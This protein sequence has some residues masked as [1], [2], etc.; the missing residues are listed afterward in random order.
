MSRPTAEIELAA[1]E[2]RAG[3]S[4]LDPSPRPENFLVAASFAALSY[5]SLK[6]GVPP[7][8]PP[9]NAEGAAQQAADILQNL[10]A[11]LLFGKLSAFSFQAELLACL[12]ELV[13]LVEPSLRDAD[14]AFPFLQ[15]AQKRR[16]EERGANKVVWFLRPSESHLEDAVRNHRSLLEA[17]RR[18][19]PSSEILRHAADLANY[20]VFAIHRAAFDSWEGY[21]SSPSRPSS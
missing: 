14:A 3:V 5:W 7:L 12:A 1:L 17:V 15:D 10:Q 9:R 13:N 18:N 6:G 11:E 20:V 19:A 16:L 2:A 8:I 21:A 4:T